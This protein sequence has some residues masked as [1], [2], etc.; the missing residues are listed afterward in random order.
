MIR[1]ADAEDIPGILS[2]QKAI[3]HERSLRVCSAARR[4]DDVR[5][6]YGSCGFVPW[7]LEMT[8]D[9]GTPETDQP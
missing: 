7:Y 8:Q 9:L 2:L 6:F 1:A 3:E 4:F 5:A